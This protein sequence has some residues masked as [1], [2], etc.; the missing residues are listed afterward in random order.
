MS[1]NVFKTPGVFD[2]L[3]FSNICVFWAKT[4]NALSE[5]LPRFIP[6]NV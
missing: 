1:L 5:K 2:L 3:S 6:L 4:S